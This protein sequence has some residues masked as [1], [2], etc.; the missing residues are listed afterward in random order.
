MFWDSCALVPCLVPEASSQD[1]AA[2]LGNEQALVLWW[3]T[4]VE[5]VSALEAK[6]RAP[7]STLTDELYAEGYRRLADLVLGAN[8][9]QPTE[10]VRAKAVEYLKHHPLRSADALQ[11]AAAFVARQPSFVCLDQRLRS[12]A[13][14]EG[15]VVLP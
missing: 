6:R 4:L 5:C 8:L 15:F 9:V 12:A 13:K 1:M 11:L 14:A 10:A 2:L 7:Q 3:G